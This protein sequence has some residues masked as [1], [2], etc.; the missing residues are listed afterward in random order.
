M[1]MPERAQTEAPLWQKRETVLECVDAAKE[2]ASLRDQS[3]AS[4]HL[5]CTGF[6]GERLM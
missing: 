1:R 3:D 4:E 5:K 2:P 6:I